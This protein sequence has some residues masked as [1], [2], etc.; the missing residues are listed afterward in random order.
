WAESV[1]GRPRRPFSASSPVS[2]S[3]AVPL[4]QAWSPESA[5]LQ[6]GDDVVNSVAYGLQV[7]EVL[8]IDVEAHGPLAQFLLEGLH[9]FDEGERVGVEVVDERIAF[10]DRRRLDLEDVGQP[11]ANEL[12]DRIAPQRPLLDV[13]FGGHAAV[14]L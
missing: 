4:S 6:A 11:V 8:V 5:R 10:L 1:N 2:G 3:S 14:Y 13:R 12:E 7:G 9:Q